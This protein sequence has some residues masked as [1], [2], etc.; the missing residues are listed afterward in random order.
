MIVWMR[1]LSKS[2]VMPNPSLERTGD[3]AAKA[4]ETAGPVL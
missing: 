1:G 2:Y 4:S 3:V